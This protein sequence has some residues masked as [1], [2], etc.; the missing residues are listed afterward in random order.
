MAIFKSLSAT[1]FLFLLRRPFKLDQED[2]VAELIVN[3]NINVVLPLQLAAI[4]SVVISG[5]F[6]Q[7]VIL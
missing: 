1:E 5:P 6:Q 7:R 2:Q 3:T 4:Q